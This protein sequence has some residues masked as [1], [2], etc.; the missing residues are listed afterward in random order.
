MKKIFA[1]IFISSLILFAEENKFV[2]V[3]EKNI[4]TPDGKPILLRGINL[5]NWLV[6]E[7]YMFKFE[8]TN[9][10]RLINQTFSELLG[11]DE[12]KKFWKK[13]RDN[14]ITKSDI[15]FI[16]KMGLNSIRVPFNY[17]LFVSEDHETKYDGP[18]F[19]MLDRVIKWSKEE[20]LFVVLDMHCAPG[21]QTGDN[22]DDSFGYPFLFESDEAQNLTIDIWQ[23]IASRYA[24]ETIVIGYDL[25]NEPIATHFDASKFNDK[26]EPLY[27]RI[28]SAIREVDTNHIVFLGGAQWNNNFKV[29]GA[30]F[31]KKSVYT[32]HKYWSSTKQSEVDE[33]ANFSNKYNV[34]IWMGESGE[35][36]DQWINEW[37]LLNE[38]NNFGWCFWPY[39]KMEATSNMV[40]IKKTAEWDSII[41]YANKSRI[42]FDEIRKAKPER[43]IILKAFNDFLENCKF[44]NCTVNEGYIRALGLK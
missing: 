31:D 34:P 16:K 28:V 12:T 1:L 6:P 14:Y 33:Y 24:N 11:P 4:I 9:S 13:F 22:I 43:E 7:G 18:G 20:N 42:G 2:S 17:K 10:P 35:N 5:G 29:F 27:K 30:P 38:K 41:T 32:F 23:K 36:S 25:L 39:K 40:A 19:E 26:L 3:N 21:G 44:E 37:R 8:K 15:A